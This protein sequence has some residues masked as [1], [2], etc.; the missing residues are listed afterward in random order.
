M[1][2]S[3]PP[4]EDGAYDVPD[5]IVESIRSAL[6]NGPDGVT[7][8][9]VGML[10]SAAATSMAAGEPCASFMADVTRMLVT[11]CETPRPGGE[12]AGRIVEAT[13]IAVAEA[14]CT[15]ASIAHALQ[16]GTVDEDQLPA[17]MALAIATSL[18]SVPDTARVIESIRATIA[19]DRSRPMI[20][21]GGLIDRASIDELNAMLDAPFV[22][23]STSPDAA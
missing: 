1:F 22:D 20:P 2:H 21:E 17:S 18:E 16:A 13:C 4:D 8:L 12:N 9:A 23:D 5:D 3:I 14:C 11:A 10:L 6:A 15:A 7:G 19:E